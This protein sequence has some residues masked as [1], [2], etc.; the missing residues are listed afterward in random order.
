MPVNAYRL[1]DR[2][3]SRARARMAPWAAR[4]LPLGSVGAAGLAVLLM[5]R[6]LYGFLDAG[7]AA[8]IAGASALVLR[9]GFVLAAV[10]AVST[11]SALVR[12]PD[13]G[14]VD[15]HPL[16]AGDWYTARALGLLEDRLRW[17]V[18]ASVFLLPLGSATP[19]ALL[20][21][22]G[23]WF[24]AVGVG[25][26]VNLAAP[27]IGLD[28]RWAPVLD[29]VRGVNPRPQ[30]AL[31]YAPG[32][33]LTVAGAGV[34]AGAAG[35][36]AVMEGGGGW[37]G[38]LLPWALGA[39]GFA[40]GRRA[41]GGAVRFP[42]VL[43]EIDAAWAGAEG[44]GEDPRSVYLD[45]LTR[46]VPGPWRRDLLRELRHL[47]RAHRT[48]A[49]GAWMAGALAALSAWTPGEDGLQ[50]LRVAALVGVAAIAGAALRLGATDP[51]GL[52]AR[53]GVKDGEVLRTRA[54]AV[55]AYA[56]PVLILGALAGLVRHGGRAAAPLLV[57]EGALVGLVGLAAWSGHRW[58][59]RAGWL[60]LPVAL[61]VVG[62]GV[63]A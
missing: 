23:T 43:G 60:Y 24:G 10:L 30:A 46:W 38:L 48:W 49:V 62:A 9:V 29:A 5:G 42:A 44:P 36:Q 47:G 13:R 8:R 53:L 6:T 39:A 12:G 26:A 58:P 41:A 40:L 52:A 17:L 15:L 14:V 21:L 11:Y 3:Q 56:Q 2:R 51:P 19:L 4:L 61:V 32:V 34:V 55:W 45:W 50:R 18:V 16:R 37:V 27:T 33:A 28:P 31:I 25:V 63:A 59:G 20:T 35:F 57:A 7:E 22:A 54:L 1:A